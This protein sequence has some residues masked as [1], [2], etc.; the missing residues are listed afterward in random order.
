MFPN[1][2]EVSLSSSENGRITCPI[3]GAPADPAFSATLLGKHQ[4]S[5]YY[6]PTSGL[7]RTEPPYWLDEAYQE[8]IGNIDTGVVSRNVGNANMLELLLHVLSLD[9]G[10]LLDVAGGYG[11]LTRLL[12]DKGFDCYTFDKYCTNIFASAFEP[13]ADF[14]AEVLFAFEVLEHLEDPLNFLSEL[15][16]RYGCRTLV[17][18]TLTFSGEIPSKDWWYYA[19][20]GG[21]HISFYQ[22]R[23]LALLAGKLNCNYYMLSQDL[24]IITDR[25]ISAAQLALVSNRY[26]RKLCTLYVR[27]KRRGLSKTWD[28]Q[29]LMKQRFRQR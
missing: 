9:K 15:F 17:F 10:R 19:L 28:D 2:P 29:A 16:E 23:T 24:H 18:S 13:Q 14:K 1:L 27:R 5:Y 4:V 21:Q 20:E 3:T 12:R 7:L 6:C 25:K 22:P 11:M 8:A 26:L